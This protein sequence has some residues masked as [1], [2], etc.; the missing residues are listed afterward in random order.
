MRVLTGVFALAIVFSLGMPNVMAGD[1]VTSVVFKVQPANPTTG[2]IAKTLNELAWSLRDTVGVSRT[3]INHVNRTVT[4]WYEPKEITVLEL[5]TVASS[6]GFDSNVSSIGTGVMV[7]QYNNMGLI[8]MVNNNM[9]EAIVAFDQA[10]DEAQQGWG[11]THPVIATLKTNLAAIYVKQENVGM[12]RRL[13][14]EW[15]IKKYLHHTVSRRR[16]GAHINN[17]A[18]QLHKL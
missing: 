13:Q 16:Y 8:H 10:I 11:N 1:N 7:A 3:E 14:E 4:A 17:F 6:W 15:S 12:S 18:F 5:S 2:A 9:G